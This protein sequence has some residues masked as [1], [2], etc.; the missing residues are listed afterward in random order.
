MTDFE[1]QDIVD[2]AKQFEG[3]PEEA[4]K[5]LK[6][7]F[8]IRSN[9]T[10]RVLL[11]AIREALKGDG[12]QNIKTQ[13]ILIIALASMHDKDPLLSDRE[14]LRFF[15]T[16]K[17]AVIKSV[18]DEFFNEHGLYRSMVT[19]PTLSPVCKLFFDAWFTAVYDEAPFK[20]FMRRVGNDSFKW[21]S[22]LPDGAEHEHRDELTTEQVLGYTNC[23]R[24]HL[25][26]MPIVH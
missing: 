20:G 10:G 26:A 2:R 19:S 25:H 6:R 12:P 13:G 8:G 21:V 22:V 7:A 9:K 3:T 4:M 5:K 14:L 23:P 11:T 17:K 15:G 18:G 16:T 24:E 1:I